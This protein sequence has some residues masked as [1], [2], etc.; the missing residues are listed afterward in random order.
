M[1]YDLK[2]PLD[3]E[4]FKRRCN[5]LFKK[6]GIIELSEKVKRSS[7]SNRYLHLI[8]GYLAMETGN[9]LDYAKEVFY[10]RAANSEIF[11][12]EKDDELMGK[13]EYLRSSA[14]LTQEEFSLSIDRFRDWSS[15]TAGIYLPSPNEEQ[16][17]ESIEYEMS[18]QQRWM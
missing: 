1:L 11:V 5:A 6:Q 7:Q 2:N 4:R 13:V 3:R 14:D 16:F 15:Q 10:K 9:T 17:L 18:R 12:R 8:I